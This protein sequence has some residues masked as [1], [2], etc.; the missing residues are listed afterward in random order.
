M[1]FDPVWT[2]RPFIPLAS[3]RL[4]M[5]PLRSEDVS[6]MVEQLN[7]IRVVERL[8]RVPY[9]YTLEHAHRFV[10]ACA[11]Q[12]QA[13]EGVPL[14]ITHT[15]TGEFMGMCSIEEELGIWLG[16]KFW[17]QGY[18]S[19]AMRALVHFG[20]VDLEIPHMKSS[21]LKSNTASRNIFE[22][23]GFEM[24]GEGES[25]SKAYEGSKPSVKYALDRM[26]YLKAYHAPEVRVVWVPAAAIINEE[27]QLL[28][29]QRPEG[30]RGAGQW[31]FPGGKLEAGETPE[32]ALKRELKE[33]L[34]MDVCVHDLKPLTFAS[35]RYPD[36]HLVMPFFVCQKWKGQ[37][38]P[39][40]G[41]T[42]AWVRYPDLV[43]YPTLAADI[44]LFHSLADLLGKGKLLR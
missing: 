6:A 35:Y 43:N 2:Q 15:K 27:G 38:S 25:Q 44:S 32:Q 18:G 22:R 14:A 36:F 41:Q 4:V 20:F 28:L 21:A 30:K 24:T 5:R 42:L 12:F 37:I 33:E 19:E 31:E 34:D 40:E 26:A 1:I 3:E 10:E 39:V 7:D 8:R 9:P 23:L 11:L 17:G 13:C 16:H 29:A